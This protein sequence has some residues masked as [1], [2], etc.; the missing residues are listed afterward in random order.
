MASGVPLTLSD[1]ADL[2]DVSIQDIWLKG[3]ESETS[4]Y[5]EYMNV[6]SGVTDYYLKDSSLTGLG[7]AGRITENAAV[8]A[9][10][11]VQGYDKTYTQVQFGVL[12]AFTKHMWFFGIKKRN[13]T[14]ITS[15]AR[16]A[17][18]DLRELRCADLLDNSFST[19]YL[20]QDISGNYTVTIA[21]GNG[22]AFISASQTREDG[23]SNWSNRVTDGSTVN[24]D[25]EYD[26]LK[27]AHRTAALQVGPT[28]KPLNISLDT[29]VCSRGY[30]VHNRAE[31]ILGAMNRG[32]MPGSADYDKSAVAK[33]RIHANPWITSNTSYWWMFDSSKKNDSYGF[34]YKESQ[35]ISLEG[36]NVVFK[37]GEIQY[38]ASLMFDIGHNDPRGWVGSK[39]TNAA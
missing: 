30:A 9:A 24:M 16:K 33:Y 2:I 11:P 5:K 23:G 3:S 10:S 14:K 17:C 29:F 39:N 25:F 4:L 38:K 31:E 20:A 13:L 18:S 28:G 7:Y 12:L 27:A 26:A 37:T 1:A 6:E 34:Q 22:V 21:G 8:T 19:S 36:P 32:Y 15:E 35:P